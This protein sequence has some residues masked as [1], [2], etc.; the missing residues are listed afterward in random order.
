MGNWYREASKCSKEK[1]WEKKTRN[2]F[3]IGVVSGHMRQQTS[4]N[5]KNI[6]RSA[7]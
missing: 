2:S 4:R 3:V 7:R 5:W 1:A 6:V